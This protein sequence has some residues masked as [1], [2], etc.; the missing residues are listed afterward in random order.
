MVRSTLAF[1]VAFLS[2]TTGE[3]APSFTGSFSGVLTGGTL[4]MGFATVPKYDPNPNLVGMTLNFAVSATIEKEIL[5]HSP[6]SR[7]IVTGRFD[8]TVNEVMPPAA[9]AFWGR[10]AAIHYGTPGQ[11]T[12]TSTHFMFELGGTTQA[13]NS[14]GVL[15][16]IADRQGDK[17]VNWRGT[18]RGMVYSLGGTP[19]VPLQYR[20]S[21]LTF[22][23]SEASYALKDVQTVPE[24]ATWSMLICGFMLAGVGARRAGNR[25]CINATC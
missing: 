21:D 7:D 22:T 25:R 3:A 12:L 2:S 9:R 17:L 1:A 14:S 10:S 5:R 18:A 8:A 6:F 15:S 11:I 13:D 23:L 4:R 20:Y 19:E 24:P 16:L